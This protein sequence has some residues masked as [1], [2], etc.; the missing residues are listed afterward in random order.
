[1][2][3]KVPPMS[4]PICTSA[5][6]PP[7]DATALLNRHFFQAVPRAISIIVHRPGVGGRFLFTAS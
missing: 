3:V 1:M 4:T 7:S 6:A 2:S 5:T